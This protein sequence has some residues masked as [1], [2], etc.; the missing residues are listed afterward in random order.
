MG[1]LGVGFNK[2][3][4]LLKVWLIACSL[5][6]VACTPDKSSD[7]ANNTLLYCSEAS[8]DSFNPQLATSGTTIDA[9]SNQI[10][11]RLVKIDSKTGKIKS[12]LAR[13]VI[14][15]ED[16]KRY[17]FYLRKGVPFHSTDYFTPTR[18]LTSE[19]VLFTFSRMIKLEHDFHFVGGG[20]YP[21]FDNME[22]A[23][24]VEEIIAVDELTVEFRLNE[25][26]ASF[27]A[28]MAT[29]FAVILSAE[30][31]DILSQQDQ[32]HLLD[33]K[34]IGTG[35]YKFKEYKRDHFIRYLKHNEYWNGEPKLKQ[36]VYDITPNNSHRLAK[37][38]TKECD[39]LSFPTASDLGFL[40]D[41][42]S[43]KITT[44][45]SMNVSF[46]AFNTN[47]EPLDDPIVRQ[48]LAHAVDYKAILE[49]VYFNNAEQATSL[50][51][52]SS[53]AHPSVDYTREYSLSKAKQLLEEAG[54]GAGFSMNIWAMT[55]QRVYNP[56]A[57]KMAEILQQSL[58]K[59]NISV[60][61]ITYEWGSYTTRLSTGEHDSVLLGWV[62]DNADPDNFYR[63]LLSCTAAFSGSNV[64][65]W[66]ND[67]Y[68]EQVSEALTTSDKAT[69]KA[70]YEDTEQLIFDYAPLVPIAYATRHKVH[71]NN[72]H[73]VNLAPN[74]GIDLSQT[75]KG[76]N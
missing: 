60:N 76:K 11:S 15:S 13:T 6:S 27:L 72:I 41:K 10:Y 50:L 31:A 23:N 58:A 49:A 2:N 4:K 22:L 43:I 25:P 54:Y 21:F 39:V 17:R 3:K 35:P 30:Y 34:P 75:T 19:D 66:C 61:I 47:A 5:L 7:L 42:D 55:V 59:L 9:V 56:N 51:P 38:M 32:K 52:P 36:I 46:W 33:Q 71:R 28:N 69:R 63:S 70:I 48:A 44:A 57:K 8:P 40:E 53:W 1:K 29:D 18:T 62:A 12:D 65:G 37:L 74:G 16:A 26:Q 67:E 20:I 64:S 45:D 73:Q 68:D 24:I 14:V